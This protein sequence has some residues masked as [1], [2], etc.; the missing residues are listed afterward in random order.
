MGFLEIAGCIL[1]TLLVG[2]LILVAANAQS[3]WRLLAEPYTCFETIETKQWRFISARMG[4]GGSFVS[5]RACLNIGAD[6]AGVYL[7]LFPLFR[8]GNPPLFIPWHHLSL[9]VRE[10]FLS[11]EMLFHFREAPSVSLCLKESLGQEILTHA[12]E[13]MPQ[14]K[15]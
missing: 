8:L 14:L 15:A 4:S 2:L 7:S 5:F 12:P 1:G 10:G 9:E 6:R 13:N 11:S 3:G